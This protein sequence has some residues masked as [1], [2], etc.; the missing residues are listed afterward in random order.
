MT[1]KIVTFAT[2][3]GGAGKTTLALSLA[4]YFHAK[5]RKVAVLDTD[6]NKNLTH[7]LDK[8]IEGGAIGDI[9]HKAEHDEQRIFDAVDELKNIADVIVIDMAGVSN[10]SLIY[11][12]GVSS[13][14]VIPS[15]SSEDDVL[16]A[17]RTRRIL[18]DVTRLVNREIPHRVVLS[19]VNPGTL[20][21]NH[22]KKQFEA[23]AVDLLPDIPQRTIYQK[24]RFDATSPYLAGDSKAVVELERFGEAIEE[25]LEF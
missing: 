15:K 6:V 17:L 20:V 7:W 4:S 18:S 23:F 24:C 22:S 12:M 9:P 16:E 25:I 14:V 13:L 8:G 1:S 10:K 11:A 3:K 2:T 21:A 19:Q 5:G